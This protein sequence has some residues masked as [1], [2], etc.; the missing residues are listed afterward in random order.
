MSDTNAEYIDWDVDSVAAD[1]QYEK[2]DYEFIP[3]E[4]YGQV[5]ADI[6]GL[7]LLPLWA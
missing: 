5:W 6:G 3:T 7:V 2:D 1:K 4:A